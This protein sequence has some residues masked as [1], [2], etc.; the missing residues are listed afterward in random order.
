MSDAFNKSLPGDLATLLAD[1]RVVIPG[2][3]EVLE[4]V[5]EWALASSATPTAHLDR[6]GAPDMAAD[7]HAWAS[8]AGST[9]PA[10]LV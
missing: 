5:V 10:A 6:D 8:A 9:T 1:P 7:L 4:M 2:E 3:S